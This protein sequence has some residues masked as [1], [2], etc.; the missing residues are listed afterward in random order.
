MGGPWRE[1]G[2]DPKA[3]RAP[4]AASIRLRAEGSGWSDGSG[5]LTGLVVGY[6]AA[7]LTSMGMVLILLRN[8]W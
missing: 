1:R 2:F 7:A 4:V 3:W 5:Q 8:G 6:I